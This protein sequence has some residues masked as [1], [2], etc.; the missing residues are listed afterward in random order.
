MTGKYR[1]GFSGFC[2]R[3][4]GIFARIPRLYRM[5]RIR[6]FWGREKEEKR[7]VGAPTSPYRKSRESCLYP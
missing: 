3:Q 5:N 6:I 7:A 1:C 2:I 4:Y